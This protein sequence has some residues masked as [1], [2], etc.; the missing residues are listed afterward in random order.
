MGS[1]AM[2]LSVILFADGPIDV[3]NALENAFEHLDFLF[4]GNTVGQILFLGLATW[5]FAGLSARTKN[6]ASELFKLNI[7]KDTAMLSFYIFLLMVTA[8]PIIWALGW[9]NSLI[10][11]PEWYIEFE[12]VQN[13]ILEDFLRGDFILWLALLNIGFVPAICE[14][15]LFRGYIQS[16]FKRSIGVAGALIIPGIL[17][18]L[19]HLKLTQVI[20]LSLIGILLAWITYKSDSLYPA[21]LAH[22]VNN[23][24]T[25][26][27]AYYLPDFVFD[28]TMETMPGMEFLIPSFVLSAS[29][30][31][32]IITISKQN[33]T[34]HYADT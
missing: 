1:L 27:L 20:P 32:I 31:Y 11:F 14:E 2:V 15:L 6:R 3:S 34:G 18:G 23:G 16:L 25:V 33:R 7:H 19:Y 5:Y 29:L 9:L 13:K 30:V 24:G 8:Q 28:D 4:L 10:P 12:E 21:M 26:V 22:L 17:F